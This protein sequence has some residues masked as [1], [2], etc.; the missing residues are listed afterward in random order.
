MGGLAARSYRA[1]WMIR[2]QSHARDTNFL[3][4]TRCYYYPYHSSRLSPSSEYEALEPKPGCVTKKAVPGELCC[5]IRDHLDTTP[6]EGPS[7]STAQMKRPMRFGKVKRA[8]GTDAPFKYRV[9]RPPDSSPRLRTDCTSYALFVQ[10]VTH[11][12]WEETTRQRSLE[13]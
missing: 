11:S 7:F 13:V 10:I 2:V 8:G 12:F 9:A 3:L 5:Q 4:F 6:W 1:S